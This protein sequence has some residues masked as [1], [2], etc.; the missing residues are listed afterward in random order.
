MVRMELISKIKP[1]ANHLMDILNE[2]VESIQV[3]NDIGIQSDAIETKECI[4]KI[5]RGFE[6]Q[7]KECNADIQIDLGGVPIIYFP[8][9]YMESIL[10]NLLSNALKF[11]SPNKRPQITIKTEMKTNNVILLSVS[12]NGLGIDLVLHKD[13]I[14]KIRKTFHKHPEAK[15]FGLFM[16]KTQVEAMNGKL[17]V[18]SQPGIGSTFYVE[19]KSQL[20]SR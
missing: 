10:T 7:I 2:L 15:G 17:W 6:T 13:Q 3:K 5:L 12:D 4:D 9:K 11:R 1:V 16:T 20:I 14:F 8:K 19:F 18:K